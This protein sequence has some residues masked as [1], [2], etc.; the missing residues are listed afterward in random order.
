MID[1]L[2]QLERPSNNFSIIEV[3]PLW[4]NH[5]VLDVQEFLYIA[6]DLNPPPAGQDRP[7]RWLIS[8]AEAVPLKDNCAWVVI[9]S[10]CLEHVEDDRTALHEFRRILR[11][12]GH[13]LLD[14]PF[15]FI[16]HTYNMDEPDRTGHRRVYGTDFPYRVTN[17]GFKVET[18]IYYNLPNPTQEETFFHCRPI[19]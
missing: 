14:V 11:P 18:K 7:M 12:D 4:A 8:R 9:S 17:E 15:E 16:P 3:G 2:L 1:Y 19:A 13:L 10:H 5:R 6:L